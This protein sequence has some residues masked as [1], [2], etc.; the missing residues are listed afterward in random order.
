M[1]F[2]FQSAFVT[3]AIVL[4]C[5]P[6]LLFA[7][8]FL[9]AQLR[10]Y[11]SSPE[12]LRLQTEI[13]SLRAEL[14][15]MAREY[16]RKLL[17]QRVHYEQKLGDIKRQHVQQLETIFSMM[18][19]MRGRMNG[20]ATDRHHVAQAMNVLAI[21]PRYAEDPLDSKSS[22]AKSLFNS[23]I[24]YT[25][26]TGNLSRSDVV[27]A[28][29]RGN[30]N[31]IQI[32]AHGN[33]QYIYLSDSIPTLPGW[34]GKLVEDHNIDLMVVMS[35]HSESGMA[36]ALLRSGV[37]AVIT[38]DGEIED[39]AAIEFV[40]ALYENLANGDS[41][42]FAVERARLVMEFDQQQMIRRWGEDLWADQ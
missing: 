3:L 15:A 9:P 37:D 10:P 17:E 29:R 5:V 31:V 36:D 8:R 39:N 42:S 14:A 13:D 33:Q 7:E 19:D 34:W 23:G 24:A 22:T 20:H 4:L 41:L 32:D 12:R 21:W 27:R 16:E 38:V 30:H 6:V 11:F 26:L 1:V 2:D 28:L 25:A 18:H 40:S 35:C